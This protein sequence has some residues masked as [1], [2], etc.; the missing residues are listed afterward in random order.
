MKKTYDK[1]KAPGEKAPEAGDNVIPLR[2]PK[3]PIPPLDVEWFY[4]EEAFFTEHMDE[5]DW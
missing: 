4:D 3:K 1:D 2:R 5:F